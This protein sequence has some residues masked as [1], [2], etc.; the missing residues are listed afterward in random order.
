MFT[1]LFPGAGALPVARNRWFTS[2]PIVGHG[3]E[4]ADADECAGAFGSAASADASDSFRFFAF[5]AK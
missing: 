2:P 3:G 5:F 4:S 1:A